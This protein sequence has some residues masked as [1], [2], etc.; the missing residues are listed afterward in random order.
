MT[1]GSPLA[2]ILFFIHE[3]SRFY[4]HLRAVLTSVLGLIIVVLGLLLL[5]NTGDDAPCGATTADSILVGHRE[6]VPLVDI[7]TWTKTRT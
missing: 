6:Q 2:L 4:A 1:K 7:G 5:L 3:V